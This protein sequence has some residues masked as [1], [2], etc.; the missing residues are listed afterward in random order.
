MRRKGVG[1]GCG[2]ACVQVVRCKPDLGVGDGDGERASG[3]GDDPETRKKQFEEQ[4][5]RLVKRKKRGFEA[6]CHCL[7][8][9]VT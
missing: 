9:F 3:E 8:D 2:V 4:I 1:V 6:Q 5:E 7:H